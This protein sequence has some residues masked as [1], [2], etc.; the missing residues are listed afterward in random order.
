MFKRLILAFV[1]T[2]S[3][4][5]EA[6]G[7]KCLW[8]YSQPEGVTPTGEPRSLILSSWRGFSLLGFSGNVQLGK[9][10]IVEGSLFFPGLIGQKSEQDMRNATE[11]IRLTVVGDTMTKIIL[12]IPKVPSHIKVYAKTGLWGLH[13]L[14]KTD[15]LDRQKKEPEKATMYGYGWALGGGATIGLLPF[16]P[17]LPVDVS[18][19]YYIPTTLPGAFNRYLPSQLQH[20]CIQ[21]GFWSI[22]IGLAWP[23]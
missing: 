17:R 18:A 13:T 14:S 7:V 9:Y 3:I 16:W 21:Q 20:N 23:R 5:A 19:I 6:A 10:V 11:T 22:K 4:A 8:G 12:P 1:C 15:D 2:Y